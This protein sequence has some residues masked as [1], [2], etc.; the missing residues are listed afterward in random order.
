MSTI[1]F[2]NG[3]VCGMATRGLVRSG[4]LYKPDIYN[5]DGVYSFFYIDFRRSMSEFSIGMFNE[6][7]VV[8]DSVQIAVT[9]I[10]RVSANVYKIYGD[11]SNRN[12]GITVLN[13]K[14]SRLR[15]LNGERL[16]AFSTHMFVSGQAPYIDGGYLY[17]TLPGAGSQMQLWYDTKA[18]DESDASV[19]LT[20]D[21]GD[22]SAVSETAFFATFDA[23]SINEKTVTVFL[24]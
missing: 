14:T 23:T 15:F 7:I 4:E 1:D 5:D 8:Y 6:S 24:F 2:R 20:E 17:E 18:F 16:P 13:K 12:H 9:A 10:S 19:G 22:I 21:F 11:I 3:F